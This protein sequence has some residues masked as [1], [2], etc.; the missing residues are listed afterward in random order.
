MS[1][2][3]TAEIQTMPKSERK[4]VGFSDIF[5]V[6]KTERKSFERCLSTG[7]SRFGNLEFEFQT[8]HQY[9]NIWKPN[10]TKLVQISDIHF[11]NVGLTRFPNT[12]HK[13]IFHMNGDISKEQVANFKKKMQLSNKMILINS[14]ILFARI[15]ISLHC[16]MYLNKQ[17]L[18]IHAIMSKI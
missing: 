18:Q 4:G 14:L 17:A 2:I 15:I 6:F 5:L 9:P 12:A 16:Q 1:G 8:S 10:A 3:Q 11:T 13:P 7:P